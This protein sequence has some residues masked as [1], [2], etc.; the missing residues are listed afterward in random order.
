[1]TALALVPVGLGGT[2]PVAGA[3]SPPAW[4]LMPSPSPAVA[5]SAFDG[6]SCVSPTYCVAVGSYQDGSAAQT[7]VETWDG[8]TWSVTPSPSLGESGSLTAVFCFSTDS[9]LALGSAGGQTLVESW[10]GT[11][12]SLAPSTSPSGGGYQLNGFSCVSPS[13]CTGVGYNQSTAGPLVETWDGSAW[14]VVPAPTYLGEPSLLSSVSCASSTSCVAVGQSASFYNLAETWDGTSWSLWAPPLPTAVAFGGGRPHLLGAS[15]ASPTFCVAVG[16]YAVAHVESGFGPWPLIDA[17]DGGAWS[18]MP[19]PNPVEGDTFTQ[20]SC[21]SPDSCVAIGTGT[22]GSPIAETWDGGTWSGTALPNPGT[23][24]QLVGISCASPAN[25]VAV[26]SLGSG[27]TEE[28]LAESDIALTPT[29]TSTASAQFTVG[30][31]ASFVIAASGFPTPALSES[32]ALPAGVT[33]T[34]NG[35]G[36]ATLSGAPATG[37]GGTYPLVITASN[38]IT[39]AAV[40]D[41]TLTVDEAPSFTAETPPLRATA[42]EL[43]TYTFAASG[44]PAPSYSLGGGSPSWLSIDAATGTLSGAVPT[45]ARSFTYSVTAANSVGSVTAG[46]FT[47]TVRHAKGHHHGQRRTKNRKGPYYGHRHYVPWSGG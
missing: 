24:S 23:P 17:W 20:V 29:V 39:P 42:R 4:S 14:S 33:F 44:F 36:T 11:A 34:D 27:S 35:N 13:Y 15:C 2:A 40:Q 37:T 9:C 1:V 30:S 22:D 18:L 16:E 19:V 5:G 21:A 25:C 32:G 45:N 43:Y 41:F 28:A 12:W 31:E 38:G 7:L 3:A 8:S 47:V 26:G 6:V 10:D 46:P